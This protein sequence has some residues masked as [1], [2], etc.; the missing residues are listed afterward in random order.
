MSDADTDMVVALCRYIEAAAAPPHLDELATMAGMGPSRLL[1]V[2]KAHTGLTPRAYAAAQRARRVR[3]QLAQGAAVTQAMYDAGY[4][5]SGRFYEESTA[6]LG[7]TPSQFK[8][9]GAS[10]DIRFAVGQCSLGAVLVAASAQGV[11]AILLGDDPQA[12]V[13]DL[14][15]RFRTAR[16]IGADRGFEQWVAQVVGLIESP[17]VGL[18][19]PLDIRG[20]AFQQR[21]WQALRG[22]PAGQTVSYTEIARRIGSPQAVRAVAGACAANPL[23]V[24]IPCHR[25]VRHDGAL[26]GYRWGIERK[27]IL[28]YRE[29]EESAK[30]AAQE[31]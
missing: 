27:R 13:C 1:R 21:V 9:G 22:I 30:V 3:E 12:L 10:Q 29:A 14:Q 26:S 7:M 15:D 4:S 5:S 8:A 6:V 23:A 25:V 18:A 2:F 11:C 17:Q 28:L 24:A 16:L 19:L 31:A 20:T